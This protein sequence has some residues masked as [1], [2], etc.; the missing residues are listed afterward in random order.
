MN[1][2]KVIVY[3]YKTN[4]CFWVDLALAEALFEVI[5]INAIL[6]LHPTIR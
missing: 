5:G 4:C 3:I 1:P 6:I 2:P